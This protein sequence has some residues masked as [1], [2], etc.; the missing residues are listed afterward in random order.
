MVKLCENVFLCFLLLVYRQSIGQRNI[1]SF[2]FCDQPKILENI[3]ISCSAVFIFL[4]LFI[5][6]SIVSMETHGNI[7]AEKYLANIDGNY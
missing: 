5:R 7:T 4:L 6:D 1:C 2:N 3:K